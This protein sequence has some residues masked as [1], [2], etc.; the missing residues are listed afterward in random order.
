VIRSD[1]DEWCEGRDKARARGGETCKAA[2]VL[3]L[4]LE[5]TED[6]FYE[7]FWEFLRVIEYY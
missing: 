4:G 2:S 1:R 3:V 6:R 5:R 7:R